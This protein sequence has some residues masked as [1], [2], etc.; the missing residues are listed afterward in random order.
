[1]ADRSV[2]L[3]ARWRQGDQQAAA[4]LF[5]RYADRLIALA[6]GRL[7]KKV[8][9]RVDP[10][11]V[12]QS[13]YRSFFAGA[14]DGH[15]ELERGGD[16]WRLL[17]TITLNKLSNQIKRNV[18]GKR[19]VEREQHFGGEDSLVG[20]DIYLLARE[21]A[22]GEGVALADE[23]EQLMR[24]L[25]PL[26]R[27]MLELRLQ[28]SKLEE[29]AAQTQRSERTVRRV[30]EEIKQRLEQRHSDQSGI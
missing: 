3:L 2:S 4:E 17:V 30:L 14:R 11:D 22:P 24:G 16:L 21:P 1:V 12:V 23:L 8:A 18:R 15:Y 19:S 29:I 6:R 10:E 26:E 5:R 27:Q 20:K 28:G 7:S 9:Q 25:E 13:V